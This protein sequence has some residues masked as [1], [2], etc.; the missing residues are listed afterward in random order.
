ML[1]HAATATSSRV[2][3]A[4]RGEL[5]PATSHCGASAVP[6]AAMQR[7]AAAPLH[8]VSSGAKPYDPDLFGSFDIAAFMSCL[9]SLLDNTFSCFARNIL[10]QIIFDHFSWLNGAPKKFSIDVRDRINHP[11]SNGFFKFHRI[12]GDPLPHCEE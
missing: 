2:G 5:P 4:R 11:L 12:S 10:D 6:L 8:S 1:L 3:V 9:V 7:A